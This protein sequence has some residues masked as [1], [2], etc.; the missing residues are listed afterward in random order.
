MGKM[1]SIASKELDRRLT[2]YDNSKRFVKNELRSQK[3]D[4]SNFLNNSDSLNL[5]SSKEKL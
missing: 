5:N 4:P 2:L 3:E 1:K